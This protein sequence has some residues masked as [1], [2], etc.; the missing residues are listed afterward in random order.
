MGYNIV[1]I[2]E[3]EFV[4]Q[5]KN[6]SSLKAFLEILDVQDR[7]NPRDAFYGGRTNAIKLQSEGKI[8]YVDFTSLYPWTNKYCRL[9][10]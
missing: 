5:K 4:S 9:V 10:F 6:D 1:E 8:K 7:L 2:W 3:H